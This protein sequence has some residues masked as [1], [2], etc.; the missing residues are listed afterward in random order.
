MKIA[1]HHTEGDF[2]SKHWIDYCGEQK[3]TYIL[4]NAYSSNIIEELEGID[5]FLWHHSNYDYRDAL[6]AKQLLYS[7]NKKGIRVFPNFNTNWHF[8]DKV[9]QKYLLEAIEAPLIPSYVFYRKSEALKWINETSFPKVFKLRG[10]SGSSNVKL[11]RT[12]S[13][14]KKI[15]NKAFGRGFGQFDR[16]THL[17]YR[18]ENFRSGKEG[19]S[20]VI[21]GFIRLF[22]AS[23]YSNNT[24]REKGYVYF[25][26]FI[27]NNDSDIRV[28]VIKNRAFAIKRMVRKNDF[29]ASGSGNIIYSKDNINLDCIKI[30]FEVNKKI[31]SQST[32][33]DFVFDNNGLP[34]I[35]EISYGFVP[36]AYHKCEGYWDDK[37]NWYGKQFNPSKWMIENLIEDFELSKLYSTNLV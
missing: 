8:D 37:M 33:F 12:K 17:R 24:S 16:F 19:F 1:I 31:G 23:E 36:G 6:F 15:I 27:P 2:F 10:G 4:V 29:R 13:E 18:I 3:L 35:V 34:K 9:G 20:A 5:I 30:A 7:L 28:I 32:A 14:A 21:K 26:D 22:I 25:Q 11:I